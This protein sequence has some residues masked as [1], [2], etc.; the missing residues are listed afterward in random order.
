MPGAFYLSSCAATAH[1]EENKKTIALSADVK[2]RMLNI[3]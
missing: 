3:K 1:T 2:F